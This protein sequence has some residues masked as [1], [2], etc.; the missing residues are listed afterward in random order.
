MNSKFILLWHCFFLFSACV[1]SETP[2]PKLISLLSPRL[3]HNLTNTC[4]KPFQ[5]CT[6][7]EK[8]QC[9][10]HFVQ[11]N[12]STGHTENQCDGLGIASQ[13]RESLQRVDD[14]PALHEKTSAIP[15]MASLGTVSSLTAEVIQNTHEGQDNALRHVGVTSKLGQDSN[16]QLHQFPFTPS[17]PIKKPPAYSEAVRAKPASEHQGKPR[18]RSQDTRIR[19]NSRRIPKSYNCRKCSTSFS[20]KSILDQHS[21]SCKRVYQ[22]SQCKITVQS[23]K[24]LLCH[25]RT[26]QTKME[27]LDGETSFICLKCNE[28]FVQRNLLTSHLKSCNP[29]NSAM[30]EKCNRIFPSKSGLKRHLKTFCKNSF[31]SLDSYTIHDSNLKCQCG[32]EFQSSSD[33]IEHFLKEHTVHPQTDTDPKLV[34]AYKCEVCPGLIS[35]KQQTAHIFLHSNHT[36]FECFACNSIFITNGARDH[37][38]CAEIIKLGKNCQQQNIRISEENLSTKPYLC[39][40]CSASMANKRL[41]M[42]HFRKIHIT[43][44]KQDT[45]YVCKL[46]SSSTKTDGV[47][48]G[49]AMRFHVE[50]LEFAC[51]LCA[52]MTSSEA[53]MQVHIKR[54]HQRHSEVSCSLCKESFQSY[55]YLKHLMTCSELRKKLTVAFLESHPN[56]AFN[57]LICKICKIKGRERREMIN[58]GNCYHFQEEIRSKND[59]GES[60]SDYCDV[61]G[62]CSHCPHLS[63]MSR[64]EFFCHYFRHHCE[65]QCTDEVDATNM[66]MRRKM[67]ERNKVKNF[68]C[69][70]CSV[71]FSYKAQLRDHIVRRHTRERAYQCKHCDKSYATKNLLSQHRM[72]VHSQ[73]RF[74]CEECGKTFKL[75]HQLAQHLVKHKGA[76]CHKCHICSK[77][78][79][80]PHTLRAH[81]L[82]HSGKQFKCKVCGKEFLYGWEQRKHLREKHPETEFMD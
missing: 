48:R 27:S 67:R 2:R 74:T 24:S 81:V 32:Q 14:P 59:K 58:H 76:E 3:L 19:R 47:H 61:Q 23:A 80:R 69:E 11:K 65:K 72:A 31:Q 46:C 9:N 56:S 17:N 66:R 79:K 41:F 54:E 28:R 71:Q 57:H 5:P 73:M 82:T 63:A 53:Q 39:K 75:K 26:C 6:S 45:L 49:H 22:C 42:R 70:I 51:D 12:S 8:H 33:F 52:Y 60:K 34:E 30:C 44:E 35:E 43:L 55:R 78:F 68:Q 64:V 62:K 18:K 25:K 77:E 20:Q 13:K 16:A 37:H 4:A 38:N 40:I 7:S 15:T 10:D 50:G 29:Q 36:E 21:A 1:A